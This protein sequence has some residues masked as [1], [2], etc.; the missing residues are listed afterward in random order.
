[1]KGSAMSDEKTVE[2]WLEEVKQNWI[3][4]QIVVEVLA[5]KTNLAARNK[6]SKKSPNMGR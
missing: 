2:Q 4:P 6:L 5:E 3:P 1:M